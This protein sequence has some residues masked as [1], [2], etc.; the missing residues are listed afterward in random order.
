MSEIN[1]LGGFSSQYNTNKDNSYLFSGM[2]G[3]GSNVGGGYTISDYASIRNGSY[4]KLLKAYYAKQESE[5]TSQSEGASKKLSMMKSSADILKQAADA[6][7]ST[8][9]WEKK[10]IKNKDEKT[11]IE[12]EVEDYDW[13]A[14]TKA[15]K[16]FVKS[17]NDVVNEAGNSDSKDVLRNG[18]WMTGMTGKTSALLNKAGITIGK[19]NEL[20]LDEEVLKKADINVLRSLFHGHNSL[21][22]KVSQKASSISNA[23]A[24]VNGTYTKSGGYN[25]ALS[26]LVSGKVDKEV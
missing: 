22:N 15:V 24:R 19:N 14:I 23:V 5:K 2:S 7:N 8:S 25:N 6:L 12:T 10:T 21:A 17:Y 16:S 26:E 20:E 9:L 18:V 11:G 1:N 3:D 13:K 4:G